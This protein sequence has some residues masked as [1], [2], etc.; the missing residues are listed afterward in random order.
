LNRSRIDRQEN[1]PRQIYEILRSRILSTELPPGSSINERYLS[2]LL[3]V[4]RTPIREAIR[5]L[6][7]DGLIS[8]VPNVGT[9]VSTFDLS[10]VR[11][12]CLIRTSFECLAIEAAVKNFKL[13]DD[14]KLSQLIEDQDQTIARRD[15]M[16]NIAIDTEFHRVIMQLSEYKVIP[17]FM[18]RT[19][20]EILRARHLS[21]A[22]PGRL[23][24]PIIE[25]QAI[26]IAL[27]TGNPKACAAAMKDHLDKSYISIVKV[28]E[29]MNVS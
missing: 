10:R 7:N 19:M 9:T 28:L 8:I 25:H 18:Q 16:A 22:L 21:I 6:S 11:E 20:G 3:G 24:E 23:R 27:R 12:F 2:E 15:M 14:Q 26:L 13:A 17:E 29:S 4:S 5:R 1:V